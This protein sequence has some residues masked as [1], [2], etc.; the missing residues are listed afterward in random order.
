MT[1]TNETH[2]A[3]EPLVRYCPGCGSIGAVETKY[4]D[5]CPDGNEARMI[6][7]AL[8]EKCRATFRLAIKAAMADAAANDAAPVAAQA[9]PI[10]P[11]DAVY[12]LLAWLSGRD[13][14]VT[15][16]AR[17]GAAIAADLA[18]AFCEANGLQ[19]FSADYPDNLKYP[20][21]SLAQPDHFRGVTKMVAG[22]CGRS[23]CGGECGNDWVGMVPAQQPLSGA[24][25]LPRTDAQIV[26]QT[27]ELA[28]L[29]MLEVYSRET[30]DSTLFRNAD[31]PRGGHVWKIACQAQEILTATDPENSVSELDDAPAQPQPSGKAGELP[32]PVAWM[33]HHAEPMV[34][35]SASE[36]AHYC[37]EGEVPIPLVVGIQ[38]E[39]YAAARVR[40]ALAAQASGRDTTCWCAA[41]AAAKG[42]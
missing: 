2:A 28:R 41:R 29:L 12:G 21:S 1:Q 34:F 30:P 42:Q 10:T 17:H 19:A 3:Q 31:D 20:E 35:R 39:D 24:D 32:A 27:E 15:L 8:A 4:R 13:E 38:A 37:G 25:G 14:A 5:C 33:T 23:E 36:C 26:A 6:P 16:S 22:C 9:Q 40:A 11:A 18:K 7:Q